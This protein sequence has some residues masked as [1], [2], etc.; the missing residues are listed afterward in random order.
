MSILHF[1]NPFSITCSIALCMFF[2]LLAYNGDFRVPRI[3]LTCITMVPL[4]NNLQGHSVHK[5]ENLMPHSLFH[6]KL[7]LNM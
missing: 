4:F 5:P 7:G 3:S 6:P 2:G 1:I